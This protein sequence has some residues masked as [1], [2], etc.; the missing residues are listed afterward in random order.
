MA[1]IVKFYSPNHLIKQRLFLE[2]QIFPTFY[3][4]LIFR[5]ENGG[6]GFNAAPPRRDTRG[7]QRA[8]NRIPAPHVPPAG[9]VLHGEQQ[10]TGVLVQHA[11]PHQLLVRERLLRVRVGVRPRRLV[12]VLQLDE[13]V[14]VYDVTIDGDV[15]RQ[16]EVGFVADDAAGGRLDFEKP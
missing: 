2:C 7:H 9:A 5:L 1:F 3:A 11:P 8:E 10:E 15:Q 6:N 12:V 14:L 13:E 16:P 4:K